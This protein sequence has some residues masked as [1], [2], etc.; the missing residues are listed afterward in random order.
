MWENHQPMPGH[1]HEDTN[2]S[3]HKANP[4]ALQVRE[5]LLSQL[6]QL[7]RQKL[8]IIIAKNS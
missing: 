6:D 3:K 1:M 5:D 7:T 8:K 2:Q 4:R